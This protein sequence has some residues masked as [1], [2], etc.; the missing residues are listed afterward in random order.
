MPGRL[1]IQND[2]NLVFYN[3]FNKALWATNT[4]IASGASSQLI[5]KGSTTDN[6]LTLEVFNYS[7]NAVSASLYSQAAMMADLAH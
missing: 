6:S 7:D 4:G 3:R 5:L 2:G 1:S